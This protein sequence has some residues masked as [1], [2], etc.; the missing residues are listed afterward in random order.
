VEQLPTTPSDVRERGRRQERGRRPPPGKRGKLH[1]KIRIDWRLIRITAKK[2]AGCWVIVREPGGISPARKEV[3]RKGKFNQ[4]TLLLGK[5]GLFQTGLR[6]KKW[7]GGKEDL[8]CLFRSKKG[9]ETISS[10]GEQGASH[11]KRG[12][13]GGGDTVFDKRKVIQGPVFLVLGVNTG[14]REHL[15]KKRSSFFRETRP[16]VLREGNARFHGK[17][18]QEGF[19]GNRHK[20]N[21][22]VRAK[23]ERRD[24]TERELTKK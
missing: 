16:D 9:I 17:N 2:T 14:K 7:G 10:P 1:G 4:A 3:G 13:M 8:S 5:R 20:G 18:H 23:R 22:K 15:V 19:C 11:G 6:E 21:R 12:E 24:Q